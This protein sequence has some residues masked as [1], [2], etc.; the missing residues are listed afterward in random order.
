MNRKLRNLMVSS[1]NNI[2][3]DNIE[4]ILRGKSFIHTMN[5]RGPRI[6]PRGTPCFNAPQSE[7][8]L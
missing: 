1:A 6:D 3:Y 4:F 2:G 8:K 7:K 5:N